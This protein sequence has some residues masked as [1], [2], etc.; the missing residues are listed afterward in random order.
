M[1]SRICVCPAG[2]GAGFAGVWTG[3]SSHPG[4]GGG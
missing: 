4:Q 1:L 3:G 2:C